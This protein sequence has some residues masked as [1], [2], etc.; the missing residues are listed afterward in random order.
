MFLAKNVVVHDPETDLAKIDAHRMQVHGW[1][2]VAVD[3]VDEARSGPSVPDLEALEEAVRRSAAAP[4][5]PHSP[6]S[7][8]AAE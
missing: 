2:K 3:L 5:T 4:G 7:R 6:T 8:N 1:S